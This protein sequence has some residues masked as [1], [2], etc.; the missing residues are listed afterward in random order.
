MAGVGHVGDEAAIVDEGKA[1]PLV[2]MSEDW[3]DTPQVRK[4]G[5][6]AQ[7]TKETII[8]DETGLVV[9]R[10]KKLGEWLGI[11]RE[12]RAIDCIIDGNTTD[13]RYNWQNTVYASYQ[14]STPWV[15]SKTSNGLTDYK[16]ID[17]ARQQLMAITDP[18][19][20]EPQNVKVR[21]LIVTPENYA[22]ANVALAPEVSVATPGYAT[23]SNPVRGTIKNPMLEYFGVTPVILSSQLLKS[24]MTSASQTTTDWLL[25]DIGGYAECREVWPETFEQFGDMGILY[26]QQDVVQQFKASCMNAFAVKNP[27]RLQ[28]NAA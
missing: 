10:V 4:R 17:A 18:Q 8:F 15:N 19:T 9:E 27:R 14:T 25:G 22:Q 21:H 7:I 20:G 2:G 16:N 6:L 1:Y 26:Q 12:K 28:R 13:H 3:R 24:R 11:S 5:M 23:S